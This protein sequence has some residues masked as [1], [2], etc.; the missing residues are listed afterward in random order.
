MI[1]EQQ[2]YPFPST[3]KHKVWE[4]KTDSKEQNK[5]DQMS[6]AGR[7]END[8]E[9]ENKNKER[10]ASSSSQQFSIVFVMEIASKSYTME[11][12]TAAHSN[13]WIG[14][15]LVLPASLSHTTNKT[16]PHPLKRDQ[17]NRSLIPIS[18]L[19]HVMQTYTHMLPIPNFFFFLLQQKKTKKH[20]R[21]VIRLC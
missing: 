8:R 2:M 4:Q 18:N 21:P 17:R 20:P 13:T 15:V 10:K 19:L 11:S 7:R 9:R 3:A 16:S 1:H 5:S 12:A 14:P 6:M